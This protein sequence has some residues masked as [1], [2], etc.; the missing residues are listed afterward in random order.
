M[1]DAGANYL[2]GSARASTHD[3][4]HA[5]ITHARALGSRPTR[6]HLGKIQLIESPASRSSSFMAPHD[7]SST[8]NRIERDIITPLHVSGDY[9]SNL[10]R[11]SLRRSADWAKLREQLL[12]SRG[13]RCDRAEHNGR[14]ERNGGRVGG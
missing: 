12:T 1:R 4:T 2:K 9:R 3:S 8:G 10:Q 6:R 5:R 7:G 14:A 11:S 13:S